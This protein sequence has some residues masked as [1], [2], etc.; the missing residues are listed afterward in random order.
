[1]KSDLRE[2]W[3]TSKGTIICHSTKAIRNSQANFWCLKD[4]EELSTRP[5]CSFVLER[6]TNKSKFSTKGP[7]DQSTEMQVPTR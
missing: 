7:E 1:M 5:I 2:I 4:D 6:N 3:H